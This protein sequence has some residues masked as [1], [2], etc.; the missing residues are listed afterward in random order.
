MYRNLYCRLFERRRTGRLFVVGRIYCTRTI[1]VVE[2]V[3]NGATIW[4]RRYLN[5]ACIPR[6]RCKTNEFT[7]SVSNTKNVLFGLQTIEKRTTRINNVGTQTRAGRVYQTGPKASATHA[8]QAYKPTIPF[9]PRLFSKRINR[10]SSCNVKPLFR[11][12]TRLG[13]NVFGR[14]AIFSVR[15]SDKARWASTAV[16]FGRRGLVNTPGVVP[17][18]GS[19]LVLEC[20]MRSRRGRATML[21]FACI[22]ARFL[23]NS[24][25]E[26]IN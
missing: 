8:Y 24:P 13:E 5:D 21:P 4:F 25:L 9:Y 15:T 12:T 26:R 20:N 16:V 6:S 19:S 23:S 7:V 1:N 10:R 17:G 14:R 11:R 22:W 2:T 3:K 18:P